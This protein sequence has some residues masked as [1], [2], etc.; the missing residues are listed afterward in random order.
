M[1]LVE[2]GIKDERW[3]SMRVTIETLVRNKY[4]DAFE[5]LRFVGN[6]YAAFYAAL[7]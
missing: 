6:P 5:S 7:G 3:L 2:S 1:G 4:Y